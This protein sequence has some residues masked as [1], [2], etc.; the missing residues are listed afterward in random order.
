MKKVLFIVTNLDSGGIE[1]YLLRFLK[2]YN[3]FILP[4]V[5]CK[6][7][8]L[9]AL[10]SEYRQ[11]KNIDIIPFKIGFFDITALYRLKKRMEVEKYDTVVDFGGNFAGLTLWMASLAN[12]KNRIA[13]Y[14]GS[15]NH[16]NETFFKLKY[17]DFVKNMVLK[18][19]TSILSNSKAALNFFFKGVND[20][21]FEIIYN[22]IDS[23]KFL[24]TKEDLRNELQIPDNAFVVSHVGRYTK[25][26]N[27]QTVLNTAFILCE[28]HEDIYFILCGKGVDTELKQ[29]VLERKLEKRILLLPFR[30]DIIKVLNSSDVFFFP[31]YTEGQPNALIEALI[32]GLAFVASDI[33]PIKETIPI[34]Y[35]DF[36]IP[37]NDTMAA[38][39]KIELL[40]KDKELK[41]DFN[42][43]KWAIKNYQSDILFKQFFNKL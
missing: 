24:I 1:N 16:F 42:L 34:E 25:E 9:G 31:S 19:A 22:G 8:K 20:S 38:V 29:Q 7:G 40:Y 21:R 18:H 43:S 33:D 27:H 28:K 30:R 15:A 32:V 2:N 23:E 37:P 3:G 12:I 36:L 13:F 4:S 11:I 41:R 17:N 26:K 10:E 39:K 14:R 6:D 35:Y 5:L